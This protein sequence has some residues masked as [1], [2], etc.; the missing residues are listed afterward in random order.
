L[1]YGTAG[2]IICGILKKLLKSERPEMRTFWPAVDGL[3]KETNATNLPSGHSYAAVIFIT[4][5]L[6]YKSL[7]GNQVDKDVPYIL[8]DSGMNCL[9]IWIASWPI[10][11]IIGRQHT[12]VGV[13]G[14]LTVGVCVNYIYNM[15]ATPLT[16]DPTTS[17]M[18]SSSVI[19]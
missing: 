13:V 7:I 10:L 17:P 9:I 5:L 19:E 6:E 15:T 18:S 4:F 12:V 1:L 8:T 14:G 16:N 2:L 3:L 11:R